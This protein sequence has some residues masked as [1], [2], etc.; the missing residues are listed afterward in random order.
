MF[1]LCLVCLVVCVGG[2]YVHM[3][4]R[5]QLHLSCLRCHLRW[6][7]WGGVSVAWGHQVEPQGCVCPC[8]PSAGVTGVHCHAHLFL[9]GF[10]ELKVAS[11]CLQG[12]HSPAK[13]SS[14]PIALCDWKHNLQLFPHSVLCLLMLLLRPL[15]HG[16]PGSVFFP[17]LYLCSDI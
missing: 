15:P 7:F 13:P 17:H 3:G 14:S 4:V 12:K 8:P 2:V 1:T 16:S 6:C 11:S 5:G 10:W 9:C